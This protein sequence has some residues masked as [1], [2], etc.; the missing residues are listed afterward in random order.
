MAHPLVADGGDSFQLWR[1]AENV[2]ISIH[3]QLTRG[4]PPTWVLIK[5]LTNPNQKKQ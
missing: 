1:V 4:G 5:G 2:L 3:K